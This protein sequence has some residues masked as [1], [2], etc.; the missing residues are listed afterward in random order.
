MEERGAGDWG[1]ICLWSPK[2]LITYLKA[3]FRAMQHVVLFALKT[4]NHHQQCNTLYTARRKAFCRPA[5]GVTHFIQHWYGMT[6]LHDL[7]HE[8]TTFCALLRQYEISVILSGWVLGTNVT[9][10]LHRSTSNLPHCSKRHHGIDLPVHKYLTVI[11]AESLHKAGVAL[12]F[13]SAI[14]QVSIRRS[15]R[16]KPPVHGWLK[17]RCGVQVRTQCHKLHR[18]Q[19]RK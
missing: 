18:F 8:L 5:C 4:Y 2:Y 11:R 15:S 1:K 14:I 9:W 7:C 6:R 3:L 19:Q 16:H 13:V 10:S 12:V 17:R